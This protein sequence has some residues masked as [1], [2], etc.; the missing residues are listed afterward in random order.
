MY[1]SLTVVTLVTESTRRAVDAAIARGLTTLLFRHA[2]RATRHAPRVSVS[3]HHA[4]DLTSLYAH[5]DYTTRC[6]VVVD[7]SLARALVHQAAARGLIQSLLGIVAGW[8][9]ALLLMYESDAA[10]LE[11]LW[12][13]PTARRC[14]PVARD[15]ASI[16]TLQLILQHVWHQTAHLAPVQVTAVSPQLALALTR[17]PAAARAILWQALRAPDDWTVDRLAATFGIT[18]RSFERQ[19]RRW[20]LPSPSVLLH[21]PSGDKSGS[22]HH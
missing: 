16:E 8:D 2:P 5:F 11:A 17:L 6:C 10:A 13:S 21:R 9:C 12:N 19:C 4:T 20:G 3:V 7:V 15:A 22:E 18:R 1:A 14:A